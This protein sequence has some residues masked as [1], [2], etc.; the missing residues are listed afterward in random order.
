MAAYPLYA[1]ILA[2]RWE[3]TPYSRC[4]GSRSLAA[5][6][7]LL[8]S[9]QVSYHTLY[10]LLALLRDYY[11]ISAVDALRFSKARDTIRWKFRSLSPH[12]PLID[13]Y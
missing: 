6:L 4:C 5:M 7:I 11:A 2:R 8:P 9:L 10:S 13:A 3:G 12:I 1:L